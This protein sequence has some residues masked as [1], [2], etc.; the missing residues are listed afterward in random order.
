M[1]TSP[2]NERPPILRLSQ[3]IIDEIIDHVPKHK[4]LMSLSLVCQAL[5]PRC[6][7]HLFTS[8]RFSN[9]ASSWSRKTGRFKFKDFIDILFRKPYIAGYIRELHLGVGYGR[10][11]EL[12]VED[13][14][15]LKIMDLIGESANGFRIKRVELA[16]SR[17]GP[18]RKI[19]NP[20]RF[21]ESLCAPFTTPFLSSLCIK[22]L[23][24]VP[25]TLVTGC[26][27][28]KSLDLIRTTFGGPDLVNINSASQSYP[29][30]QRLGFHR[31]TQGID[32]LMQRQVLESHPFLN[33]S[34][35]K[36][37]TTDRTWID[38]VVALTGLLQVSSGSL[39][40]LHLKFGECSINFDV[41]I[42]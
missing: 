5:R 22:D 7:K 4:D 12:T 33:L 28:L 15:F 42:I 32:T 38:N 31:C 14:G 21:A 6:E 20:R 30:L 27:N 9:I 10:D 23:D 40:E 1:A 2:H 26:P 24:D 29:Q 35:L 8:I 36:I 13:P 37:I 16:G 18:T 41:R 39:E 19:A 34:K 25:I 11:P 3:E 17:T